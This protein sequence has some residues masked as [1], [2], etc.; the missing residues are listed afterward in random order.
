MH[1]EYQGITIN[2][3]NTFAPQVGG[4]YGSGQ[5]SEGGTNVVAGFL[6]LCGL[7]ICVVHWQAF[8]AIAAG[9]LA[10]YLYKHYYHEPKQ[11]RGEALRAEYE[12]AWAAQGDPRG[13]YGMYPPSNI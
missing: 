6:F 1:D 7:I 12:Q 11:N 2:N 3:N 8:V 9:L 10:M 13:T 5:S 4:G